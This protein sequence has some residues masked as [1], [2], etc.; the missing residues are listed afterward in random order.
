MKKEQIKE[1]LI[2]LFD[3]PTANLKDDENYSDLVNVINDTGDFGAQIYDIEMIYDSKNGLAE[4][5]NETWAK[6]EKEQNYL[7]N[8]NVNADL[9]IV[10]DDGTARTATNADLL[11][12]LS[13]GTGVKVVDDAYAEIATKTRLDN[14]KTAIYKNEI[15]KQVEIIDKA[16]Y[17]LSNLDDQYCLGAYLPKKSKEE[18]VDYATQNYTIIKE[19]A[20][21]QAQKLA[22]ALAEQEKNSQ[23]L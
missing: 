1:Y 11:E 4:G 19:R 7:A 2:K 21:K 8:V 22:D 6:V 9:Y 16:F 17:A 23:K 20:E 3:N 12:Y 15:R 18:Y 13:D 14:M 10:E 5:E